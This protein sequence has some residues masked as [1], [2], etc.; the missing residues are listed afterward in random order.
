MLHWVVTTSMALEARGA[1]PEPTFLFFVLAINMFLLTLC[2]TLSAIMKRL[3]AIVHSQR[4]DGVVALSA[5]IAF[6]ECMLGTSYFFTARAFFQWRIQLALFIENPKTTTMCPAHCLSTTA[7][8]A[9]CEVAVRGTMEHDNS[10]FVEWGE[11]TFA[12]GLFKIN[13]NLG[14]IH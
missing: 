8:G 14:K 4:S 2:P 13:P 3:M 12:I 9:R 5:H 11:I 6:F 7:L 1:A 10:S